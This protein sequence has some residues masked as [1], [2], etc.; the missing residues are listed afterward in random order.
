MNDRQYTAYSDLEKCCCSRSIGE[1]P[2]VKV[3]FWSRRDGPAPIAKIGPLLFHLFLPPSPSPFYDDRYVSQRW[4][5]RW[6]GAYAD[7]DMAVMSAPKP[8]SATFSST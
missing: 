5:K 4:Y 3:S 2:T 1:E 6:V 7:M 8:S